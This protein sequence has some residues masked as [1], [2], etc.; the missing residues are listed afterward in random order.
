MPQ[1]AGLFDAMSRVNHMSVRLSALD[2]YVAAMKPVEESKKYLPPPEV[3]AV[4]G[5]RR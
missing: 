5:A 3:S 4:S 2:A 1:V